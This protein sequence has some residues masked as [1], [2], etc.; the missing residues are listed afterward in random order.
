MAVRLAEIRP[1]LDERAWRL[2]LGAEARA[3]GYGGMKLV[4]AA[5]RAKAD[6][7]RGG[8]TSR[9]LGWS[10]TGGCGRGWRAPGRGGGR[11]GSGAGVG[12]AG[13]S[14]DPRGSAVAVAVDDEVDVAPG[15]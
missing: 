14:G 8:C 6:T 13:G 3:I 11:P 1:F 9:S 10:R 7:C 5:A 12:G 2:L 4:A 15:R